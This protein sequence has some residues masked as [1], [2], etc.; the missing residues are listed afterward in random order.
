MQG[1]VRQRKI[2]A[3]NQQVSA[4]KAGLQVEEKHTIQHRS[5]QHADPV[6]TCPTSATPRNPD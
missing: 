1:W 4:C 5:V 2:K 6:S 3:N